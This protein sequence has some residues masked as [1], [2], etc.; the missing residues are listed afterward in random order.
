MVPV[1][2]Y[3]CLED[4]AVFDPDSGGDESDN[5]GAGGTGANLQKKELIKNGT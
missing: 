3:R 4:R 5:D 2:L 1:C